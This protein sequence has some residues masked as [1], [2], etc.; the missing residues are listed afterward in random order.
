MA[1][2]PR[3]LLII[4]FLFPLL[5]SAI[6]SPS[7]MAHPHK[8]PTYELH[9]SFQPEKHQL[10]G[11][12]HISL[13][14][15]EDLYL[16]FSGLQIQSIIL[17][18]GNEET[19]QVELPDTS[20]FHLPSST[21]SQELFISYNKVVNRSFDNRINTEGIILTNGWHPI[22]DRE[23]LFK[24][25]CKVPDG[26]IAISET[27]HFQP[28]SKNNQFTFSSSKPLTAIH[29]AAAPY[30]IGRLKI[31]DDLS[32]FTLFF[33][34]DEELA[35][36]YLKKTAEY[37]QRYEKEIGPFPYRHYAVVE[38]PLP[39]GYGM[40]TFTL[41]GQM[42]IRLPFIKET[43]LGHEVLHSWFGNSIETDYSSGNWCEGLVTYLAD[44][45]YL[46]DKG[47]GAS[48]RK[49]TLFNYHNYV[50]NTGAI[51]LDEFRS[52]SHNQ[53]MAK[54]IRAVGY[55]RGAMLFHELRLKLGDA[56]F[57]KGL[58]KFYQD[59]RGQRASWKDIETV[60]SSISSVDLSRFFQERLTF[61]EL[62]HLDIEN[63]SL[64]AENNDYRLSFQ[65][66]Q[67]SEKPFSIQVPITIKTVA[68]DLRITQNITEKRNNVSI[69]LQ[70][71]PLK[72]V[73][74]PE[75]DLMRRLE[76]KEMAPVLSRFF[77]SPKKLVILES[78]EARLRFKPLINRLK[79]DRWNITTA[80]QVKNAELAQQSIL[81]LGSN[82]SVSRSLFA[83]IDHPQSGFTLEVRQNPLNADHVAILV[84]AFSTDEVKAV[85]RRLSHYGKYS[86]LHFQHGR[87]QTKTIAKSQ[88]GLKYEIDRLPAGGATNSDGSFD[89][90]INE[91]TTK[92]VVYV[93]E[94]HTSVADHILQFRII[95]ALYK[96]NPNLAIG[97]EMFPHSSQQALDEYIAGKTDMDEREFL[98]KSRYFKVWR[99]DF[100]LFRAIFNFAKKNT[101]PVIGL[102]LDR[103][104]VS[105]IFKNSS[106]DSLTEEQKKNIP[107]DRKLDMEGYADRL[108][109]VHQMHMTGRHGSGSFAGFIQSQALWDET[110][111]ETIVNYLQQH[112]QTSM[113]VLAGSQ[114]TRKDSGI[115]PRVA[116]R[117]DV[118]QASVINISAGA[119]SNLA[120]QADY[121]FLAG[122]GELEDTAK[123]GIILN[124]IKKNDTDYLQITK[125]SPHGNA[126]KAGIREDDILLAINNFPINTMEDVRIAMVDAAEGQQVKVKVGRTEDEKDS[127]VEL[128]VTLYKPR[129]QKPHP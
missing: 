106:T 79:D 49:N 42:V 13:E 110:M 84:S 58:K 48:N 46:R 44:Q 122:S 90:I 3:F 108:R 1:I 62:S 87:I 69:N 45:A 120:Q 19:L 71:N 89:Q 31:R 21:S 32:V 96:K 43:S 65:I 118:E 95:E 111:A 125:I 15:G 81:F 53:P 109:T 55:G 86:Y 14:P 124:P 82:S 38:N 85:S 34:E 102:N 76:Q 123:M 9:V 94:S 11:T 113:V 73:I 29:L 26:F 61:K 83:G 16:D 112:P 52:A 97:M 78:E 12:A 36:D 72:I 5:I 77:G 115:P 67:K 70:D 116:R 101:I 41:L 121:Y 126:K 37:I 30:T 20:Q 114:H 28:H 92:R 107:T 8:I 2:Y 117:M 18:R 59:F 91:L 74:D 35:D 66:V 39:V 68:G 23:S 6:F 25:E 40:D 119:A 129:G 33:K 64:S 24:L 75:Y 57:S 80:Q 127:K 50:E 4:F 10:N 17:N 88:S 7:I 98:K 56:L 27:D 47:E 51:S 128:L 60:F 100:R 103:A 22:P 105:S 63:L 93:G 104:I 99:Y 54:A